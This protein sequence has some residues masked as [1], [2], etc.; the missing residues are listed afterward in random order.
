MIT[1]ELTEDEADLIEL[2]RILK[3]SRHNP[4]KYLEAYMR[5]LID[6]LLRD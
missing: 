6:K 2:I 3:N 5:E 4:S 1:K